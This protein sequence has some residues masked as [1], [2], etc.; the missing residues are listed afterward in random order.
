MIFFCT[1]HIFLQ[2]TSESEAD[3]AGEPSGAGQMDP[4]HQWSSQESGATSFGFPAKIKFK[5]LPPKK[6]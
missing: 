5:N 1:D 6:S 3:R 4:S 2:E